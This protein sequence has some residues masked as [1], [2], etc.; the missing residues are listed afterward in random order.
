MNSQDK[1][2]DMSCPGDAENKMQV[3]EESMVEKLECFL[4]KIGDGNPVDIIKVI[5]NSNLRLLIINC[6]EKIN[7]KMIIYKA[8]SVPLS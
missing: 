5:N 4:D 1:Y 6:Q 8:Q 2:F 7:K 3:G